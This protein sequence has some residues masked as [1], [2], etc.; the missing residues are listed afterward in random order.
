[1]ATYDDPEPQVLR[2]V[3]A[4]RHSGNNSTALYAPEPDGQLLNDQAEEE[5]QDV[6]QADIGGPITMVN[7]Q[8]RPIQICNASLD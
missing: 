8:G 6:C 7:T 2:I 1:M 5:G 4:V 3:Q